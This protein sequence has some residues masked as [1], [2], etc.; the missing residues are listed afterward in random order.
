[1]EGHKIDP[2]VYFGFEEPYWADYVREGVTDVVMAF[3]FDV[4]LGECIEQYMSSEEALMVAQADLD[5]RTPFQF[6]QIL[7]KYTIYTAW[8]ADEDDDYS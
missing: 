5:L 1:V 4:A 7:G 6:G 8:E 2:N 3:H